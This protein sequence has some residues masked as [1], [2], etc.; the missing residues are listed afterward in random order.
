MCADISRYAF[1]SIPTSI[2]GKYVQNCAVME[3]AADSGYFPASL[4]YSPEVEVMSLSYEAHVQTCE[5]LN[6][7]TNHTFIKL[8]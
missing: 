1:P 4:L 6:F 2:I 7:P 5:V 3:D 8:I